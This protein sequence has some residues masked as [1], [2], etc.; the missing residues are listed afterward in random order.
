VPLV[1]QALEVPR[2]DGSDDRSIDR[3]QHVLLSTD[4]LMSVRSRCSR[5]AENSTSAAGRIITHH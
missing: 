1:P 4:S 2:V 3:D 5:I